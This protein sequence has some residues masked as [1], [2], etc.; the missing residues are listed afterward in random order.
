MSAKQ[1]DYNRQPDDANGNYPDRFVLSGEESNG[2]EYQGH[3]QP[4]SQA[5]QG[6]PMDSIGHKEYAR[7]DQSQIHQPEKALLGTI[8]I[9]AHFPSKS[10]QSRFESL[11]RREDGILRFL[12]GPPVPEEL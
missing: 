12:K 6:M 11:L 4:H 2:R 8:T 9:A 5:C 1:G 7:N 10:F 3:A